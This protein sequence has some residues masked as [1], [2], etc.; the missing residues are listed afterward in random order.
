MGVREV[1]ATV[2]ERGWSTVG[3]WSAPV[4]PYREAM[5][6]LWRAAQQGTMESS[7]FRIVWAGG[8]LLGIPVPTGPPTRNWNGEECE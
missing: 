2:N 4:D 3:P 1:S 6:L 5:Q 8:T 7:H